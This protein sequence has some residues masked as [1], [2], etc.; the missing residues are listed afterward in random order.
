MTKEEV[1]CVIDAHGRE[2]RDNQ[3]IAAV[4]TDFY[5]LLYIPHVL[6]EFGTLQYLAE[7]VQSGLPL[8]RLW[9]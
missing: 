6:E 9:S 2:V 8:K 3:N 1:K 4:F 7:S 5:K